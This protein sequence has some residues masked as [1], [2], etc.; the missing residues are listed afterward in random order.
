MLYLTVTTIVWLHFTEWPA[1]HVLPWFCPLRYCHTHTATCC[2]LPAVRPA[3]VLLPGFIRCCAAAWLNCLL[4][5]CCLAVLPAGTAAA[6]ARPHTGWHTGQPV[7]T[8]QQQQQGL[9]VAAMHELM[10]EL[11]QLAVAAE[12]AADCDS[13]RSASIIAACQRIGPVS[14]PSWHH[15]SCRCTSRYTR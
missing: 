1:L 12:Q 13:C 9:I 7:S 10:S 4:L 2:V 8:W 6:A 11:K 3:V 5:C 15:V 14:T